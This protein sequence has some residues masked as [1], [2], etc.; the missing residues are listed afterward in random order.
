MPKKSKKSKKNKKNKKA[1]SAP[2]TANGGVVAKKDP[3]ALPNREQ[4]MFDLLVTQYDKKMYK[5][6]IKLADQIYPKVENGA[7]IRGET[8]EDVRLSSYWDRVDQFSF[9]PSDL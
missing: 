4:Q 9:H 8:V 7:L 6:A 1:P 2:S 3:Q 5:K